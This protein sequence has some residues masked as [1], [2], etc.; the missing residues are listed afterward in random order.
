MKRK[1]VPFAAG[2][3]LFIGMFI[4]DSCRKDPVIP[5][6]TT[7]DI[8]N[9]TINSLT[10]GGSISSDGR[11]MITVSGVCYG[12]S[13][14][15]TTD[16][17]HTTDGSL[18][19]SF[20]SKLTGLTP[21]T[22]YYIRAYA[23]NKVGTAYGNEVTATTVAVNLS[24]LTTEPIA[25]ITS[26]TAVSGGNIT[27]GGNDSVTVR[28]VCWATTTGPTTSNDV[29]LDGAGK[30]AFVSNLTGL[31][32]GV[33]YYVRAYATNSAGVSYG[34]ELTFKTLAAPTL[35]TTN[36]TSI[37]STTAA[38]GGNITDDGGADVTARGVCW[39]TAA[40]PTTSGSK[41]S[42][43]TGK[44][45]FTSNITGLLPTT[46]YHVRAYATNSIGT[47]YGS[48]FSFTTTAPSVPL[49][50]TSVV[51][52]DLTTAIAGGNITSDGGAPV[53]AKGVCWATT[54]NPTTANSKTS[55]GTGTGAFTS[56]I[57][58]LTN[59]TVYYIRAYATNSLGT[60]YGNQLIFSTKIAD[61]DGNTYN[62]ILIGTQLWMAEN[63]KTTKF[64]DNTA[65]PLVTDNTLWSAAT[66]PA[67]CY[68]ANDGTTN[69]PKYG[70]IYN[71]Y[72][73]ATGKLCPTGW[74][75][76]TDAEFG[77]LEQ[78]LGMDPLQLTNYGWRGTNQGG[79]MKNATGWA[80]GMNGTNTSGWSALPGGY[81]YGPSGVFNDIGLLSYFWSA[82]SDPVNAIYR[83]LDGADSTGVVMNKV[84]R[85]G[86]V[87]QGGKYIRCVHN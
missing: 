86:V 56:N 13:T 61:V 37:G 14:G 25:S 83:R 33:T 11:S 19:G 41:T 82:T 50:T 45:I 26:T 42:D 43:G 6:L 30:G 35:T 17:P 38:S 59:G 52:P 53:T 4:F 62:T 78:F 64:N 3:F 28:G 32:P 15:P 16:S 73:V 81:R 67:Y 27:S 9:V 87:Y 70:T 44:G 76:P 72:T 85:G 49:L 47:A 57:A 10:T 29:T 31:Q 18:G 54:A 75:V 7:A 69:K 58:G 65:I 55:D 20:V 51:A 24:T 5:S 84:F 66:S 39:S 23:T 74:H 63:L 1:I 22:M 79:Q 12:T 40:N 34:N 60:S 2:C 68:Y 21:N 48:D 8:T 80:T 46:V 71:F 36:A 77:T